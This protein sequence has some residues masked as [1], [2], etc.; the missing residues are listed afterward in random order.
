MK[1]K[2]LTG[3]LAWLAENFATILICLVL[4]AMV[5]A[6]VVKLVKDKKKGKS[7]CGGNCGCCPMGGSC[8]KK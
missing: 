6:I 5:A 3:M 7:T 8:H 1:G 2:E 4:A